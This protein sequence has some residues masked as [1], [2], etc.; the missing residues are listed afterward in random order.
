MFFVLLFHGMIYF[1]GCL[2]RRTNLQMRPKIQKSRQGPGWMDWCLYCSFLISIGFPSFPSLPGWCRQ[3]GWHFGKP[4][5]EE[6][7]HPL[8][9]PVKEGFFFFSVDDLLKTFFIFFLEEWLAKGICGPFGVCSFCV[10]LVVVVIVVIVLASRGSASFQLQHWAGAAMHITPENETWQ[11]NIHHLKV[12]THTCHLYT[13][14]QM[15]QLK[16][17]HL[18]GTEEIWQRLR[19]C[20]H[21]SLLKWAMH[22]LL[23]SGSQLLMNSEFRRMSGMQPETQRILFV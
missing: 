1:F 2:F 12:I 7:I 22:L 19:Q 16:S 14:K 15:S 13:K 9:E 4:P 18:L 3:S 23:R 10:C 5:S 8:W 20:L 21:I 11:W 6:Y 17:G